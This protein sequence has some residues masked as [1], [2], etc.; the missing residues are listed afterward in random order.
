MQM[1]FALRVSGIRF[2]V[3]YCSRISRR[4]RW[5]AESAGGNLGDD[6]HKVRG[7]CAGTHRD[8]AYYLDEI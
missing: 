3:A 4:E 5:G 7:S 1:F 2:Q 6:T 8:G